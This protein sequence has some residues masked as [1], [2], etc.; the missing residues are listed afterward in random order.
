MEDNLKEIEGEINQFK[1]GIKELQEEIDN[2]PKSEIVIPKI[3]QTL[4]ELGKIDW[5]L[6]KEINKL[7]EFLEDNWDNDD[8]E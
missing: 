4:E 2:N 1:K 7:K 8:S 5:L 6:E 3:E